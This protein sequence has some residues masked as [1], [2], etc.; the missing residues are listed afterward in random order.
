[1]YEK[2]SKE[3]DSIRERFAGME[4]S[5]QSIHSLIESLDKKK[6]A[7]IENTFADVSRHF[8]EIFE[9]LVP[10]GRGRLIMNKK[11]T[12]EVRA[13]DLSSSISFEREG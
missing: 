12:E 7:A 11:A 2:Y 4:T 13:S 8:A 5:A 3:R 6:D 9:K 1:M 10:A